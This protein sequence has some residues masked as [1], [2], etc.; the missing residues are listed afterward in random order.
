MY[1]DVSKHLYDISIMIKNTSIKKILKNKEE[2]KKLITYKRKEEVSRIG[3]IS[4]N[5]KIKDFTYMKLEFDDKLI[6]AFDK[7]Q[8]I[9]VL[10]KESI[11]TTLEVENTIK[12]L[13]KIFTNLY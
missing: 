4:S 5:K 8:K 11:I 12:L 10:D 3:G 1:E 7:M 6:S 9:Y 2:L 13:L